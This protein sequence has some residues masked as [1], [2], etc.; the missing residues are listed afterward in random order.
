MK[1]AGWFYK[2]RK[3][4][5]TQDSAFDALLRRG[6]TTSRGKVCVASVDHAAAIMDNT[7][8]PYD[9][10]TPAPLNPATEPTVMAKAL[11]GYQYAADATENAAAIAAATAAGIVVP[12]TLTTL[13]N[14]FIEAPEEINSLDLALHQWV[15]TRIGNETVR[16]DYADRSSGSGRELFRLLAHDVANS[17]SPKANLRQQKRV[18]PRRGMAAATF[19]LRNHAMEKAHQIRCSGPTAAPQRK[20]VHEGASG[21]G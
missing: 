1:M 13:P 17:L 18:S 6:Y 7:Y 15:L 3:D 2:L 9:Y 10:E 8:G 11:I 19:S 14:R 20:G 5:P 12:P 16:D 4:A 21:A